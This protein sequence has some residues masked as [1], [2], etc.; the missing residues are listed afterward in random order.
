MT[1]VGCGRR[2]ADQIRSVNRVPAERET[3]RL[4]VFAP[5]GP[6]VLGLLLQSNT[7]SPVTGLVVDAKGLPVP[8]AEVALAAGM[9]RDGS[10]PV[11]AQARADQAGKFHFPRPAPEKLASVD[12]TLTLW[13]HKPGLGLGVIDLLRDDRRAQVHR[14]V[15][16]A[17]APR[18]LT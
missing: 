2:I 16:E 7:G 14:L 15:L 11:L 8:G 1:V 4:H 6:L 9:T 13:A 17:A 3:T 12:T 5:I 18:R 10:V